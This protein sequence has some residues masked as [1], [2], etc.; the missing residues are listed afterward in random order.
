MRRASACQPTSSCV[1]WA[2]AGPSVAQKP[3]RKPRQRS[4]SDSST[5]SPGRPSAAAIAS[6][7]RRIRTPCSAMACRTAAAGADSTRGHPTEPCQG[8]PLV[9]LAGG[10]LRGGRTRF[11]CDLGRP[12]R[13]RARSSAQPVQGPVAAGTSQSACELGGALE[14]QDGQNASMVLGRGW[15]VE[16]KDRGDVLL[17]GCSLTTRAS[18]MAGSSVPRPSVPGRL[19]RGA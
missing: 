6:A 17:D 10:T 1:R 18:A 9:G 15:Q 2:D 14:R 7:I 19:V 5:E 12:S 11:G 4:T 16:L 13:R 3:P 8:A